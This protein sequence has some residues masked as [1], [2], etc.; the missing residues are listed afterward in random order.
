MARLKNGKTGNDAQLA[1]PNAGSMNVA[2]FIGEL[3][4]FSSPNVFNPYSDICP[5][6]D[7]ADAAQIR[8]ANLWNLIEAVQ[9]SGV[10]TIWVARDLG[11]RGG[12]RTG[13]PLTDELNLN[14][15]ERLLGTNPLK[16][17]TRGDAVAE[18]TAAVVW[19]LLSSI[20]HPVML[21]NIFPFHP[22]EEAKPMTNRCHTAMERELT[23]PFLWYL[24]EF[25]RPKQLVAI[26]RDAQ[27][28][29]EDAPVPVINV[30]HPS[31]GGQREFNETLA[32]FYNVDVPSTAKQETMKFFA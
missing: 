8:A 12:R 7:Q 9:L 1:S 11:Y 6:I 32:K 14:T 16:R 27:A 30:R 31:Y 13:V 26:G 18:R 4:A 15:M 2:E 25:L 20:G 19:G 21:W 29:L 28:A 17:A 23:L 5:E 24:V 22:H 3:R 10:D